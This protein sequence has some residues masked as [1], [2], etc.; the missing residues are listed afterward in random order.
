MSAPGGAASSA[1]AASALFPFHLALPTHSIEAARQ[2]WGGT[3]VRVLACQR[4]GRP[5]CSLTVASRVVR[6]QHAPASARVR[7]TR[8]TPGNPIGPSGLR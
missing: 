3:M 1:A 8:Q 6:P 4:C 7:G 5:W 2:F